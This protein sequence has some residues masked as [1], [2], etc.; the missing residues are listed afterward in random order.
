MTA[1]VTPVGSTLLAICF[2]GWSER[3]QI[4]RIGGAALRTARIQSPCK[5]R[6]RCMRSRGSVETAGGNER[7]IRL[8]ERDLEDARDWIATGPTA[9]RRRP[10]AA[11]T[12]RRRNRSSLRRH[13]APLLPQ[14]P[15][16]REVRTA[17]A[18]A[19]LG[20]MQ[21]QLFEER[22]RVQLEQCWATFPSVDHPVDLQAGERALRLVGGRP[23]KVPV[24][25]G[26]ARRSGCCRGGVRDVVG[27][28]SRGLSGVVAR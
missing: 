17:A 3:P 21:A 2:S 9:V 6:D 18:V 16:D 23:R 8:G 25:R 28:T 22:G 10:S 20:R 12:R 19:D 27:G 24:G 14:Q 11:S 5:A 26:R 13:R 15:G 7:D 1:A 4:A